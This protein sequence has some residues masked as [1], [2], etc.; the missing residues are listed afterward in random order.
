MRGY[1]RVYRLVVLLVVFLLLMPG[2]LLTLLVLPIVLV[3]AVIGRRTPLAVIGQGITWAKSIPNGVS[4]RF[5]AEGGLRI[6][7]MGNCSEEKLH[8]ETTW[9]VDA[10][11]PEANGRAHYVSDRGACG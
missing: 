1:G 6:S 4:A 3:C 7:G 10:E 5:K 8:G 11:A 2:I 9:V